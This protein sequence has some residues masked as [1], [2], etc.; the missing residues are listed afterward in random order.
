M[1]IFPSNLLDGSRRW[2]NSLPDGSI[3][4]MDKLE[5]VFI[6]QWSIKEYP[7]MLLTRLKNLWKKENETIREFHS[8]FETCC[9]RSL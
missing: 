4:T 6:K 9:R 5:K 1:K 2:Y 3:K 8:R 7:N